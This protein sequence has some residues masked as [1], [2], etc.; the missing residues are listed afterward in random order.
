S[1]DLNGIYLIGGAGLINLALGGYLI[2]VGRRENNMM[3]ISNG[4][5]TLTDVW[6]SAGAVITLL[7]IRFT[8]FIVLDSLVA[9]LLALY[10]LYEGSKLLKYSMDGLMDS[11]D[12][13]VDRQVRKMLSGTLPGDM[14]SI[15]NLRHRTTGNTT[16][17]E[18]HAIFKKDINLEEAHKDATVL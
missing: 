15:H 18:L 5:H 4:K 9:A 6:T 13:G 10:I 3:V 12:P 8:D 14:R 1:S 17:I 11:R 7:I 2:K 16:W